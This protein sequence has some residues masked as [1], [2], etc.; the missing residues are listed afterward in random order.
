LNSTDV[1]VIGGGPAGLAAAIAARQ[2]GLRVVVADGARPPID[3]A[4]GEALMPDAITALEGLGVTI[5]AAEAC[6]LRGVRFL[7]SGL[8]AEAA[9]PGSDPGL[10]IRRTALAKR[11]HWDRKPGSSTGEAHDP[12]AVDNR[13]RWRQLTRAALGES[14]CSVAD[15][16]PLRF[17]PALSRTALDRP[18]GNI[19]GRARSGLCH[20]GEQ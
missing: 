1:F 12:C 7:G 3:K 11:S 8:S 20:S 2:R 6:R 15:Q 14:G 9:F 5:P 16:S 17:S 10:S 18:H 19:L 4:C 13:S